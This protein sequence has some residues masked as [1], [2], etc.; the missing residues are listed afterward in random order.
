MSI[1]GTWRKHNDQWVVKVPAAGLSGQ[2]I[3]VISK[4]GKQQEVVLGDM[5]APE[6]DAYLYSIAK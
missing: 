2:K 3:V 5:I 4:D 6:G 1:T